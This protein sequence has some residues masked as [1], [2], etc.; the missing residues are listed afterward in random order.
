MLCIHLFVWYITV[1]SSYQKLRIIHSKTHFGRSIFPRYMGIKFRLG[2][3][4]MGRKDLDPLSQQLFPYLKWPWGC[5]CW[6][7][8]GFT[9]IVID[10]V[11]AYESYLGPFQVD[12]MVQRGG[13]RLFFL[14]ITVLIWT[15]APCHWESDSPKNTTVS[16][17]CGYNWLQLFTICCCLLLKPPLE[18]L[19]WNLC[20]AM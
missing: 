4:H 12:K 5:V 16:R 17:T 18:Q 7:L 8:G 3:W 13:L 14:L 20:E 1:F 15:G 6:P 9:G 11:R 2:P 19:L 10:T